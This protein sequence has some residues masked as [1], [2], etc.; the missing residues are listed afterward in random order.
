MLFA[1]VP[2]VIL[3]RSS[4]AFG[5]GHAEKE[6]EEEEARGSGLTSYSKGRK[7]IERPPPDDGE[8]GGSD[9]VASKS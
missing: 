4:Q 2:R 7:S 5:T 1:S 6:A 9:L 8:G 3:G